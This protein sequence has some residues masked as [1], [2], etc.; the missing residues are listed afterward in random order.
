MA[1]YGMVPGSLMK[2]FLGNLDGSS[3]VFQVVSIEKLLAMNC[4]RA[5]LSDGRDIGYNFLFYTNL[6]HRLKELMVVIYMTDE[7]YEIY[8]DYPYL[9]CIIISL[10]HLLII[11]WLM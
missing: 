4:Y 1:V 2:T 6:T 8:F 7:N 10:P 3:L 9:L 5:S 11:V